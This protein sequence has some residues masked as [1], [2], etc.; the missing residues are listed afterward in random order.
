MSVR[1][2]MGNVV[3]PVVVDALACLSTAQNSIEHLHSPFILRLEKLLHCSF[4]FR[5]QITA[6]KFSLLNICLLLLRSATELH[7][8]GLAV[9]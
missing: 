7:I 8:S 6:I 9:G 2:P 4:H 3:V 5:E 1:K